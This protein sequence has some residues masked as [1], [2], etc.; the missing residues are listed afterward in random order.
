VTE[1]ILVRH[2]ETDWNLQRRVQ[3]HTDVP[4]NALGLEQ[5][6]AL[7]ASLEDVPLVAV[8][9]SDLGRARDTAAAVAGRHGLEVIVDPDLREK[10]F[11]TWEGLTD[12]EINE[13]FPDAAQ[14]AWGD[15]ETSDDVATRVLEALRRISLRHEPGP[16]LVVS[17]GGSVRAVLRHLGVEHGRI[18]NCK[19]FR[20][21]Y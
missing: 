1:I 18:G 15:G 14:G 10:H 7:A 9:A 12:I 8:Y 4:L 20:L 2:G 13:R 21:D 17:H 3:G 16:V 5:A 11:G 6:A 19:V